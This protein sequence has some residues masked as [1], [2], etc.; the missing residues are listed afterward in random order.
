MAFRALGPAALQV[1][2][3]V[4]PWVR[5][6]AVQ[7][8]PVVVGVSG[9]ADSTALAAAAVHAHSRLEGSLGDADDLLAVVVDHQLQEGSGALASRVVDRLGVVGVRTQVV[10]VTVD[11]S[12]GGG[13]EAAA[14]E[15]RL[16]ALR[17]VRP[18]A[19]LMLGHT[20][21]D[22]AE[23]VLLG[24]A[25]GS[26]TRSLSGMATLS[27]DLLR[28]LLGLRR[29]T[30]AQACR[31]WGLDTWDDPHNRDPRFLRSRV[32]AE[33][34]PVMDEVLG[35]GVAQALARTA[36]LARAD[37]DALDLWA[38]RVLDAAR[39][40]AGQLDVAVLASSEVPVAVVT[41]VLR[42]WVG[43]LGWAALDHGRTTAVLALVVDWHG[44][45]PV[46]LPGGTVR[47]AGGRLVAEPGVS[48]GRAR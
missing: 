14:R 42:R 23:S 3:A 20:L 27:G 36:G 32:R 21:D 15:A 4:A 1:V 41:R 2:Q 7:G 19:W 38:D 9:G 34:L 12:R 28:P 5:A 35:P 8:R 16:A 30:T 25:R 10:A 29:H 33:L 48:P 37:A 17:A 18:G 43:G 39:T 22:Q 13:L 44:Q 45:G 47:R 26:G 11:P 24:L 40:P 31:E 6:A 46:H